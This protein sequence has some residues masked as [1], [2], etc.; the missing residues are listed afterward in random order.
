MS[1]LQA[2]EGV[3]G[4]AKLG[5]NGHHGDDHVFH[6]VHPWRRLKVLLQ[7]ESSNLWIAIIYSAAIGLVSLVLPVAVQA[8][9]NS[10]AFGT[11]LQPLFFLT[12]LVFIALMFNSLL[13]GYRAW[14]VEVIQRKIF[15][16]IANDTTLRLVRLRNESLDGAHAPELVNRFLDVVTV[17]KAAASLLV[18][19]LSVFMQTIIG[20]ILLAVYH[21]WLLVF[22]ALLGVLIFIVIVPLGFGAIPTAVKESKA[23]F[24]LVAWLEEIAKYQIAFKSNAGMAVALR[25]TAKHVNDYLHFRSKHFRILL[26][27]IVGSFLL[28]AIASAILLGVGGWLVISRQLTLGQLVAAEIVVALVV[29]GFTKFGKHVETFYD[30]MAAVDKLGYLTD[31]ELETGGGE[32]LPR[33][34][35]GAHVVLERLTI[36]LPGRGAVVEDV[37]LEIPSG[38]RFGIAGSTGQGKSTLLDVIYGLRSPRSGYVEIDGRDLRNLSLGEVRDQVALV[39]EPEI[40]DGTIFENLNLGREDLESVDAR[41]ALQQVGLLESVMS[42]PEGLNTVLQT[43]GLPLS[44]GQRV[45]LEIAR[46]LVHKPRLLII[47][48]ALDVLDDLPNREKLLDT[49]FRPNA[50]WTLIVVS[51]SADILSRCDKTYQLLDR[52]LVP[53]TP[54]AA[55]RS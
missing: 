36:T 41:Q 6:N 2:E 42:L 23:K 47:D 40:F 29:S 16:R 10:V 22:S 44:P 11:V 27:Q 20:M 51:D 33:S 49:M 9:V 43:G 30:M 7:V 32:H 3:L 52:R 4:K 5:A 19:G 34:P 26:R 45:Q 50:P 39:R 13:Q 28:Q 12:V 37:R 14:V 38:A 31:L 25:R 17:Q 55:R 15:V 53:C 18:D 1:T 48:E 21:P 24:A 35:K 46:A 54:D 8:L